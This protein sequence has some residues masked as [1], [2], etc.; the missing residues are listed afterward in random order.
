MKQKTRLKTLFSLVL[1]LALCVFL[2]SCAGSTFRQGSDEWAPTIKNCW[3]CALYGTAFETINAFVSDT[4]ESCVPVARFLLGAGLLFLLLQRIGSTLLLMPEKAVFGVWKELAL[5]FVK[6]VFVA[7]LLYNSEEFLGIVRDYVIYPVGGFFLMLSN[8]VLDAVP[9]GNQYFPGIIGITPNMKGVVVVDNGYSVKQ[10]SDAVFGDLGIQV[11][12][13]V[14]RVFSSLKSGFPLVLR[15]LANG[16]FFSWLIGVMILY[17]LSDLMILFPIVFVD[18]FI[19]IGF[20][21]VFLP[22]FLALWVFPIKQSQ[23][24]TK[25]FPVQLLASFVDI[26]FGCIVVVLIITLLQIYTD[27]CLNGVLRETAQASNAAIAESFSGGRPASI[28]FLVLVIAAKR[29]ALEIGSFTEYFTGRKNELSVMNE[30]KKAKELVKKGVKILA[31][32]VAGLAM[33]GVGAVGTMAR[34]AAQEAA[35]KAAKEVLKR[36][37]GS[38]RGGNGGGGGGP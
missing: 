17:E 12:Y 6:A 2:C 25:V 5:V 32:L 35:Q 36:A 11:Q 22:I 31:E 20:Y 28:I 18:A 33:G 24:L 29:M 30:V 21:M 14:S 37:A 7:A 34:R 23:Y 8:A 27:I 10:V 19:M 26:L 13:I 1:V 16:N 4:M 38:N 3:C 9:G 15:V